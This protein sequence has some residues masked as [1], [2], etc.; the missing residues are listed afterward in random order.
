VQVRV[1]R[2]GVRDLY[3]LPESPL[4]AVN[5]GSVPPTLAPSQWRI[6]ATPGTPWSPWAITNRVH[7]CS[8]WLRGDQYE[9]FACVSHPGVRKRGDDAGTCSWEGARVNNARANDSRISRI[10]RIH[11]IYCIDT[12]AIRPCCREITPRRPP[13]PGRSV[14]RSRQPVQSLL[15]GYP[16]IGSGPT[17]MYRP[18]LSALSVRT[19]S[20]QAREIVSF[21]N[22]H[23]ALPP[24][25]TLG[26]H[27]HIPRRTIR[28]ATSNMPNITHITLRRPR[29]VRYVSVF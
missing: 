5:I 9:L 29:R 6:C 18:T 10:H 22:H 1:T 13:R 3:G 17:R 4:Q 2:T 11:R 7:T 12:S 21:P 14:W 8:S 25:P 15:I 24:T 19:R 28:L 20:S 16:G 23:H 27:G 26:T